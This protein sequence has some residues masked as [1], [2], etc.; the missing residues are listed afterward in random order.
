[1]VVS[2]MDG[3]GWIS[4]PQCNVAACA[5]GPFGYACA[6]TIAEKYPPHRVPV[7]RHALLTTPMLGDYLPHSRT[8]EFADRADGRLTFARQQ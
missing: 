3:P 8:T 7:S 5:C 2:A 1:M 6:R 4:L